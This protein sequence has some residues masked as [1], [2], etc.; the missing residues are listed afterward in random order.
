MFDLAVGYFHIFISAAAGSY[1]LWSDRTY[2]KYYIIFF[3]LLNISWI[4]FSDECLLTY[5]FKIYSDEKYKL[6]TD[7]RVSDYDIVFGEEL[8]PKVVI[9]L[10][11]MYLVNMCVVLYYS[12]NKLPAVATI[13]AYLM[14]VVM[15]RIENVSATTATNI[16]SVNLLVNALVV[17]FL[18]YQRK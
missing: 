14:Y 13:L 16:K 10:L 7:N 15:L 1:F 12:V 18:L 8:S 2:D 5:L 9:L 3:C 11:F 17:M 4:L 6:G